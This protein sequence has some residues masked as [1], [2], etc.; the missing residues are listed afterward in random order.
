RAERLGENVVDPR[1]FDDGAHRA[2]RDDAGAVRRRLQQHAPGA[3]A[4]GDLVRD[5]RALL[6]HADQT[7]LRRLDALLDGRRDFLR[8][9]HAEADDAVAVTDDDER[10]EA[11][12]LAALD[13]LRHAVDR[14]DGV[15]DIE[16]RR[17]DSFASTHALK[18]QPGFAG[19]VRHGANAPVIQKST[20]V[21]DHAR[22][23]FFDRALGDRLADRFGA[24]QVAAGDAL[25]E[26]RLDLG[27][28]GRRRHERLTAQ[29]VDHLRVD[30]RHAAEDR[31]PRPFFGAHDALALTQLNA[32]AAIGQCFDPHYFAPVFPAFF[33][34][35]SP[36]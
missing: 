23:A 13:D 28:H 27:I 25:A 32:M 21:E 18:L 7:L 26:R 14:D 3:E 31:E 33:F 9:P 4:A 8:L 12:V 10:R 2:A 19:R 15:L 5:R 11:Q 16:L 34:S 1:R 30:V 29:V 17:I 6:R 24:L 36:V 22:D 20:A 35:T